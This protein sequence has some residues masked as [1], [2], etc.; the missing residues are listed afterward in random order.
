MMDSIREALL[1]I[2]KERR[3]LT[4]TE[5]KAILAQWGIPVVSCEVATSGEE[6]AELACSI[7]FP[8][9]LKI[10]SPD[11]IHK[12]DVGGVRLHVADEE[13][14]RAA[15]DEIMENANRS[16]PSARIMGASVQKMVSG[17][18]VAIGVTRDRQ[19]GH[20]LMF[21]I[22]GVEIESLRDVTF[23][24]IPISS[25]DAEQMIRA[26]KGFP[27]LEQQAAGTAN[28]EELRSTLLKVAD[29]AETFPQIEGMDLNPVLVSPGGTVVADARIVIGSTAG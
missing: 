1:Q 18:E 7:G 13:A 12:S 2:G 27:L 3:V 14:V 25:S 6:A 21:G 29:L 8:V 10:L 22:G 19:F 5:S 28:L 26:I 17:M 11:I 9:V 23:R 16:V 15:F 4:E 20:V 24:L